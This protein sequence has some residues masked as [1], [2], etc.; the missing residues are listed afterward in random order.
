MK[1]LNTFILAMGAA[2][3][4][5]TTGLYAQPRAVADVPFNFTVKTVPMPAGKYEL[6]AASTTDRAIQ[7]RNI[8]TGKSVFVPR[9]LS[10]DA[11]KGEASGK[12]VFH[13]YGD[14]YFFS[15][16]RTPDG[17]HFRYTPSKLERELGTG[18]QLAL[19]NI[20]LTTVGQ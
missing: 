17:L 20:P 10:P 4:L 5:G 8:E 6:H 18:R 15:E 12:I 11:G 7:M 14:R 9:T 3:L 1:T 19:A 16:A 2:A 13:R